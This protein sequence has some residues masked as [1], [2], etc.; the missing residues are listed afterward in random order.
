MAAKSPIDAGL[1]ADLRLRVEAE[2]SRLLEMLRASRGTS[3]ASDPLTVDPEDFGD[4]AQDIT[5]SDTEMALSA[6]DHRLLAQVNRAMRRLDEGVYGISEVSGKP[7]PIERLQA[8][9][10]ATTNVEDTPPSNQ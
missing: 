4:M 2:R 7:I 9:P 10:W 6:N 8:I 5:T 3:T 1:M